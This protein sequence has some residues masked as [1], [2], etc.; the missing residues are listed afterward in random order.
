[1]SSSLTLVEEAYAAAFEEYVA[2][3]QEK[4]L[5]AAYELGRGAV[6]EQ[7]SVLELAG[8]HHRVLASALR[9]RTG[10]DEIS[11]V[12]RAAAEFFLESLS[13][14][15]MVQRGFWE[16][17]DMARLEKEHAV[18]LRHLAEA[19]MD[20]NS[21]L[22]LQGIL[23]VLADRSREVVGAHW[24]LARV[25]VD[26]RR[27]IGAE[28][29]SCSD[30]TDHGRGLLN[31][32]EVRRL[33]WL[34]IPPRPIVRF[35][36]AELAERP[37]WR[38]VAERLP[39]P[40]GGLLAALLVGRDGRTLGTVH[41][42][43]KAE[44]EFSETDES[45]LAQLANTSSVAIENAQLYERERQIAETLQLRLLPDGLPDIPGVAVA[46]RYLP[47]GVGVHVGGDWYDVILLPGDRVGI[48]V[49]DVLGRGAGA[50]AL[51]GQVR[52]AFRAYAMGG[53]PPE[54]VIQRLDRLIQTMDR[55]H[56]S[57][58][59]YLILDPRTG[60]LQMVRAGHPPPLVL[61]PGGAT[62]FLER[63]HGV[64]L[65]VASGATYES[66]AD[67]LK[68]GSILVL[69]TDGLVES[70]EG[71]SDGMGRLERCLKALNGVSEDLSALCDGL[72]GEM[73]GANPEDDVALV[74]LRLL[75]TA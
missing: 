20:V 22:S 52:T 6:R 56:F 66:S 72:L 51:M 18:Q 25:V 21:T 28:A 2:L 69:Y 65:G 47:G 54:T 5:R 57:T 50:A 42:L 23:Q 38:P 34:G 70:R 60:A 10:L 64:P 40:V 31:S 8:I 9:R 74:A 45:L 35:T 73:I 13:A 17:T 27:A 43:D 37:E 36:Q 61:D 3:G 48:A 26:E 1:M 32:P 63:G 15:E 29:I 19:S 11:H 30:E 33:D 41:L 14:F 46:A 67:S 53:E 44:G 62:R 7:L 68:A 16:A 49:G 4:S 55:G 12:T 71:L 39:R 75:V 24:S 58:M 59:V